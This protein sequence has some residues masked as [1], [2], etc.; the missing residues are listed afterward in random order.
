MEVST[1]LWK[2]FLISPMRGGS[3]FWSKSAVL[4]NSKH[5]MEELIKTHSL[6]KRLL[7]TVGP[8]QRIMNSLLAVPNWVWGT[9]YITSGRKLP[10]FKLHFLPFVGHMQRKAQAFTLH[11]CYWAVAQYP[12]LAWTP[13]TSLSWLPSLVPSSIMQTIQLKRNP[14]LVAFTSTALDCFLLGTLHY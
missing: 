5:W 8:F 14:V 9:E 7:M 2:I 10:H 13:I 1:D 11:Y 4:L 12:I 6:G 3:D